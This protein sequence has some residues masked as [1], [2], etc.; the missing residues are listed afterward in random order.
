MTITRSCLLIILLLI[1]VIPLRTSAQEPEIFGLGTIS[2][3]EKELNIT[4]TIDGKRV[5]YTKSDI[6]WQRMTIVY[7]DFENGRWTTPKVA[8]FSGRWPDGDPFISPD[9][10]RLFFISRRPVDGETPKSD[11]DLWYVDKMENGR[12][13]RAKRLPGG[14]INTDAHETYP[15]VSLQ[16][17]LFFSRLKIIPGQGVER[18][19]LKS[20]IRNGRFSKTSNQ[21]IEAG[22]ND[23]IILPDEDAMI[24]VSGEKGP[25]QSDLFIAFGE[26]GY[27]EE[28]RALPLS[29]NTAVYHEGAPGI[30][31]DGKWLFFTSNRVPESETVRSSRI[32][33]GEV[34]NELRSV[35]NGLSN[36]Y[37]VNLDEIIMELKRENGGDL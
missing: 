14:N 25:G 21:Q 9:G 19:I 35:Y 20:T 10:K 34:L 24:L 29:V 6:R 28:P 27:W 18:K 7:S 23:P 30:S 26:G 32:S 11:W 33:Y 3:P 2:T 5:Y 13:S 4:T 12:W 8:S 15:S 1:F 36:I 16:G 31:M 17:N 22:F 37:R